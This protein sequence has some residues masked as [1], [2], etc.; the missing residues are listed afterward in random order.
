VTEYCGGGEMLTFLL[1]HKLN[2]EPFAAQI[3]GQILSAVNYC[4]ARQIVHR[5]LKTENILIK[6]GSDLTNI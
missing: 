3:M 1:R 5:D 4:H 6:D 2:T